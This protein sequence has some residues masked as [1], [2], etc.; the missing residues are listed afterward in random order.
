MRFPVFPLAVLATLWT[1]PPPVLAQEGGSETGFIINLRDAE[2]GELAERVSEITGRTIVLDPGVQGSVTVFSTEPLDGPGIWALFQAALRAQGYAMIGT[3]DLWRIVPEAE[4]RTGGVLDNAQGSGQD[5]VTRIVTL[6]NL[7]A[8]AAAAALRP[9]IDPS[10]ALQPLAASNAILVTDT[11]DNVARI[12]QLARNLDRDRTGTLET[13]PL[14][15]GDVARIA[16]TITTITAA[17]AAGGGQPA[18]QI[19]FDARSNTLLAR[20]NPAQLAEIR[21]LVDDLD[22]PPTMVDERFVTIPLTFAD[23]V[24][25]ADAIR[26]IIGDRPAAPVVAEDGTTVP[27]LPSAGPRISADA[28]SNTLLVRADPQTVEQ[29]RRLAVQLDQPVARTGNALTTIPLVHGDAATIATALQGVLAGAVADGAPANAA[30][31]RISFDARS[32]SLLVNA[33][34]AATAQIRQLV[35]RLDQPGARTPDARLAS[36]P[37]RFGNA[38][39]VAA[40]LQN[41]FAAQGGSEDG[42]V[43]SSGPRIAFDEQSNTLLVRAAPQRIAEIRDLAARLDLRQADDLAVIPLRFADAND[44]VGALETVAV[45]PNAAPGEATLRLS[46]DARGNAIL[47]RGAPERI[48]GIRTLAAQL[49]QPGAARIVP[50]TRVYRLRHADAEPLADILR[51]IAGLDREAANPVARSL[52]PDDRG[53]L[54]DPFGFSPSADTGPA[55]GAIPGGDAVDVVIAPDPRAPLAPD[56]R[57]GEG[58][59]PR[60]DIAIQPAPEINAIVLRGDPAAV[61][62]MV[63]L[64]DQLDS[65]RPQVLIEAAIVEITGSAGEQLGIQ[66]GFGDA[67]TDLGV[68]ATSFSNA[69]VSL[70]S[71]LSVLGVPVGGLIG[72][73]LT[74]GGSIND[75]FSIL[76]QALATS[77][78]ANLLSTP[79]LTTLDNEEAEIV[80]GQNVPFRTGSFTIDGNSTD[81]FT[82]IQREDVGITLRVAPRIN[83]GD[84]VRLSVAQEVSSLVN[85]AVTGA[86]DLITNR[87]SIETTVLADNGETIVLGGLISDDQTAAESKVPLLGDIPVAGRLFRSDTVSRTKRTLFV[88]LRPT[89]LRDRNAVSQVSR[90][91]YEKLRQSEGVRYDSGTLIETPPLPTVLS[92]PPEI[93]GLY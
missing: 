48:A 76:L 17:S 63:A 24:Q 60:G 70:G 3:G 39:T 15:F 75:D 71:V 92:L 21:R 51:E 86:A 93:G 65:R 7:G 46:A 22:Q 54:R 45:D 78:K 20:G 31:P 6:Q 83:E 28:R 42:A 47:V 91:Q 72:Q 58:D 61:E 84:V 50:V 9:L 44:L 68:A 66:F 13:Y 53:R 77:S 64:I 69:G 41:V 55:P 49:D 90:G 12:E 40:A 14:R 56:A 79:S 88:F 59:T 18:P 23:A 35:A 8:D 85:A 57:D 38:A 43:P 10:G 25:T 73:G 87:R 52:R 30:A 74:L 27:V 2:I 34:P 67:G 11:A 89:I 36:I 5:F 1:A 33:D 37:L 4:A 26:A 80:V 16:P 32:N 19:A 29:V 62:Q 82:T 81:P